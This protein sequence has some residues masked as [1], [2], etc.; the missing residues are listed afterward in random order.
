MK[1]FFV[2][3]LICTAIVFAILGVLETFDTT[4]QGERAER[5]FFGLALVA[6]GAAAGVLLL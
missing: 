5:L 4:D 1:I 3:L 6:A 2:A